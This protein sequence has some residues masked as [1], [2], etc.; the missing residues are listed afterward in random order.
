MIIQPKIRGFICTTAHPAGCRQSVEEQINYVKAAG[1]F[2]GP[3]R[4]L[5]IGASTGY[6]LATR[7]VS[8]F[9]MKSKTIGVFY[10]RG[11]EN[12]RT[13]SPGWYNTAAFEEF[14]HAQSLYAKSINGDAFS[15]AIK[16]RTADLIRQDWG[17]V[18]CVIYS[19]ASPRR[20]DPRTGHVYSSVLKPVGA[21]YTGK[22]VDT[23]T[24]DVH[25]ITLTPASAEDIDNTIAVMGGDDWELWIDYLR[26]QNLLAEG[27]VTLAY[28][29]IGPEL[30]YPIYKNG[31]IGRAKED[32]KKTSDK[33]NETLRSINGHARIAINKALVTQASAAIPVVPLY[34]SLLYRLMK[35]AGTHEGCIEQM[36]RLFHDHSTS[37]TDNLAN[38]FIRLDDY[39]MA[40]DIQQKIRDIWPE[41]CSE[42]VSDLTDIQGYREEFYHLFGFD[43]PEID[44]QQDINPVVN[45]PSILD[46]PEH[47][48]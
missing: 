15:T 19:L 6:G 11:A 33:L 31:T 34:I 7:I 35:E 24:G 23:F 30:T 45:I 26:E 40:E 9:G 14:A 48:A 8:A 46:N 27:V 5:I 21:A 43:W 17:Q 29:Y 1:S 44:V 4:V 18:D 20:Q 42:N 28:S 13:A 39:E 3:K 38:D 22:N 47:G 36:Y 2:A 10:E 37:M 41:L 25:D 16:E 12:K 32:L